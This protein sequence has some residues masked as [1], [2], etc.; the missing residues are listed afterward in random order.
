MAVVK[1]P[2]AAVPAASA[3]ASTEPAPASTAK[4]NQWMKKMLLPAFLLLIAITAA[5]WYFTTPVNKPAP[6]VNRF[7]HSVPVDSLQADSNRVKN[8]GRAS[9]AAVPGPPS[10]GKTDTLRLS[11]TQNFADLKKYTD[12]TGNTLVLVPAAKFDPHF[13]AVTITVRSAKPG[14]TLVVSNLHI[15]GFENGIDVQLPILLN[16]ENLVFEN[17]PHPF[18]YPFK[19]NEKHASILLMNSAK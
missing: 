2:V 9:H 13:A 11:S 18:R 17:T 3:T 16:A 19:P 5:G 8:T 4:S 1:K 6:V 12:S 10:P 14:D 7:I 15:T